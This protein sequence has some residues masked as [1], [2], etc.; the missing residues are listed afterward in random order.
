VTL[1]RTFPTKCAERL[2]KSR[3][4]RAFPSKPAQ[5][6]ESATAALGGA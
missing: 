2:T 3:S 6:L 4:T 5:T 1:E